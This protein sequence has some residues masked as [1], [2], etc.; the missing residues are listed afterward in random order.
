MKSGLIICL[1]ENYA[2]TVENALKT[3]I[4]VRIGNEMYIQSDLNLKCVQDDFK[5]QYLITAIIS[6]V[7]ILVLPVGLLLI[8]SRKKK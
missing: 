5:N 3:V 2:T 7:W 4:C 1:Y 8:L 6:V